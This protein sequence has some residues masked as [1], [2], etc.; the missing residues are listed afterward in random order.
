M[1]EQGV[2]GGGGAW[3]HLLPPGGL[4]ANK[5]NFCEKKIFLVIKKRKEKLYIKFLLLRANI[6]KI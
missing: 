2:R 6:C 5:H 3:M 4:R 1:S